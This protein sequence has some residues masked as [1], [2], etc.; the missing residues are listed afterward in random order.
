VGVAGSIAMTRSLETLLF[1]VTPRDPLMF[2]LAA[3]LFLG[4]AIAA[5][6][7]PSRRATLIDPVVALRA[8]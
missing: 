7:V 1:G 2:G 3:V 5:S 8:E 4:A 6:Y